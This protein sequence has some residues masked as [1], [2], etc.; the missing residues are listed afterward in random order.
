MKIIK[1]LE[2]GVFPYVKLGNRYF[3]K[4]FESGCSQFS[5]LDQKLM[6]SYRYF[7]SFMEA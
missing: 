6:F 1:D 7:K 2:I 5:D 4:T 3:S